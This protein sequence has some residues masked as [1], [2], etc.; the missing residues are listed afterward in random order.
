MKSAEPILGFDFCSSHLIPLVCWLPRLLQ[1]PPSPATLLPRTLLLRCAQPATRDYYFHF[2]R[3]FLESVNIFT[4]RR[5]CFKTLAQ[6]S[7]LTIVVPGQCYLYSKQ[8][9][10]ILQ[11]ETFIFYPNGR[12]GMLPFYECNI[13]RRTAL[14]VS[15]ARSLFMCPLNWGK[16]REFLMWR[17]KEEHR[18]DNVLCKIT[19]MVFTLTLISWKF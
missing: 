15:A 3:Y 6:C 1:S 4:W 17:K 10:S 5:F 7:E 8:L 19:I 14:S 18:A 16:T 12:K 9:Y 13:Q 2:T 11:P